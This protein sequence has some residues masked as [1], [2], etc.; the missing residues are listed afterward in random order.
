MFYLLNLF[1]LIVYYFLIIGRDKDNAEKRKRFAIIA[2]IHIVLFR[3]L[4]DPYCFVDTG[5]YDEGFSSIADMNFHEAILQ[6]NY[7]THWGHAYILL[8]WIIGQFTDNSIIMF[9]VVSIISIVPVIFFYYK[10]G[11]KMLFPLLVY[12]AYPMMFYQGMGVL[13]QHLSV[14]IILIV[15]YYLGRPKFSIPLTI[16]AC[17]MHTSGIVILP[18]LFMYRININKY[19]NLKGFIFSAMFLVLFRYSMWNIL[20]YMPKYMDIVS[21][22]SDNNIAPIAWMGS[23]LFLYLLD[24]KRN[25]EWLDLEKKI[26]AFFSYGFVI[27]LCCL[28]LNGM[29]RFT[30]CFYYVIPLASMVI[31]RR[32]KSSAIVFF[33]YA[34]N[35]AITLIMLYYSVPVHNYDYKFF[36]E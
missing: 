17:L 21:E 32:A 4:A 11:Q 33:V 24:H 31:T 19:L 7:Y 22:G 27:S 10:S 5:L 6:L 1:I 13:R 8:N 35:I 16:I 9:I 30:I 29:G 26:M 20:S 15:L 25:I 14:A 2:C 28:G 36:W 3:A 34:I 12:L 23:I 18:F